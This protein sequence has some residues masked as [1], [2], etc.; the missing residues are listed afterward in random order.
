MLKRW[1]T[2]L[3]C[4][5]RLNGAGIVVLR[6]LNRDVS[7][8]EGEFFK[9]SSL[10]RTSL[11][12]SILSRYHVL[13]CVSFLEAESCQS[14]RNPVGPRCGLVPDIP[15]GIITSFFPVGFQHQISQPNPTLRHNHSEA[16]EIFGVHITNLTP[17]EVDIHTAQ[18]MAPGIGI[19][20]PVPRTRTG[21]IYLLTAMQI[22]EC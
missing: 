19:K 10:A 4:Q 13:G 8:S 17:H 1:G 11:D 6:S 15:T 20:T 3:Y 14:R 16:P 21:D 5:D 7:H 12:P 2:I 22:M 18:T 9:T